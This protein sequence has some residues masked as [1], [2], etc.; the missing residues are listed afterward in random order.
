[1]PLFWGHSRDRDTV[2]F[3]NKT[4]TS[5]PGLWLAAAPFLGLPLL[6]I[7]KSAGQGL[8]KLFLQSRGHAVVCPRGG[9]DALRYQTRGL[10]IWGL[11]GL[12]KIAIVCKVLHRILLP[13]AVLVVERLHCAWYFKKKPKKEGGKEALPEQVIFCSN[14]KTGHHLS[15]H[16]LGQQTPLVGCL[17]LVLFLLLLVRL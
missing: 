1:M 5:L 8:T 3:A 11:Q 4:L 13:I 12:C 2:S 9:A 10:N 15:T 17:F 7:K 14:F 16:C 6:P